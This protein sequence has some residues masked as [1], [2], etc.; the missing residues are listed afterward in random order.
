MTSRL[1]REL[2]KC[3]IR[4]LLKCLT[5]HL[6]CGLAV[7]QYLK[8]DDSSEV[9]P[10][11]VTPQLAEPRKFSECDLWPRLKVPIFLEGYRAFKSIPSNRLR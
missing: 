4:E 2:L 9:L 7:S 3:L 8:S 5:L 11:E 6:E 1:I 10:S